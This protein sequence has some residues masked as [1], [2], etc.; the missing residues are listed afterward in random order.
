MISA[1]QTTDA[2][3]AALNALREAGAVLVDFDVG[4]MLKEQ[5]KNAPEFFTYYYEM[6]REIARYSM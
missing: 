2:F 3:D 6:P 1:V 5:H 4:L